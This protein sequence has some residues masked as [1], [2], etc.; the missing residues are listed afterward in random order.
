MFI[1]C[2]DGSYFNTDKAVCYAVD[3]RKDLYLV[4]AYL[5]NDFCCLGAYGTEERAKSECRK[6]VEWIRSTAGLEPSS[7]AYLSKFI[8]SMPEGEKVAV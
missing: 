7:A 2:H 1:E 4:M 6:V 5:V 8:Y 3:K